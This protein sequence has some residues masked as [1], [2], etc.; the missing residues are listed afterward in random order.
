MLPLSGQPGPPSME[1][2]DNS[3]GCSPLLHD[4]KFVRL[5]ATA[6]QSVFTTFPS[7]TTSPHSVCT[8]SLSRSEQPIRFGHQEL[9]TP[10]NQ[11]RVN[12]LV[13]NSHVLHDGLYALQLFPRVTR[14][15]DPIMILLC[16][17]SDFM[18]NLM[19]GPTTI[20][21]SRVIDP[22][23]AHALRHLDIPNTPFAALLQAEDDKRPF[24]S[25]SSRPIPFVSIILFGS[26]VATSMRPWQLPKTIET[27]AFGDVEPE[28]L[29]Q[30]TQCTPLDNQDQHITLN[31]VE[32]MCY[33]P[34][35]RC[36]GFQ[37]GGPHC[38]ASTSTF[39]DIMSLCRNYVLPG[40][41]L[42]Q[43]LHNT[44]QAQSV[45]TDSRTGPNTI[46][47]LQ[48]YPASDR[49]ASNGHQERKL[50]PRFMQP[51][52]EPDAGLFSQPLWSADIDRCTKFGQV[53]ER[54]LKTWTESISDSHDILCLPKNLGA[55][56]LST[57]KSVRVDGKHNCPPKI[58]DSGINHLASG[59]RMSS[60]LGILTTQ[61]SL[62]TEKLGHSISASWGPSHQ[63]DELEDNTRQEEGNMTYT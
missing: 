51:I 9:K 7:L 36:R 13:L 48:A 2:C 1:F 59:N 39:Q 23:R 50:H 21:D 44:S 54:S 22:L 33:H 27:L 19:A 53:L 41:Y 46:F 58:A 12:T 17:T 60:P 8:T 29:N 37:V 49:R 42:V 10:P 34:S 14:T 52:S 16:H 4:H 56:S 47:T 20:H 43:S 15:N 5:Y 11:D 57:S 35:R 63:T 24:P 3:Y 28:Y 26:T 31:N 25:T 18:S 6:P 40:I 32:R 38:G 55:L 61:H 62:Q 30:A 45:V